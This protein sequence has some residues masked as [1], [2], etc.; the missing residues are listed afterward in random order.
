M[1]T[2]GQLL[3]QSLMAP[4]I[5]TLK[6]LESLDQFFHNL[7]NLLPSYNGIN[8]IALELYKTREPSPPLFFKISLQ[9]LGVRANLWSE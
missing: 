9:F 8:W 1:L 2:L 7:N 3:K 5:T 6:L 4:K